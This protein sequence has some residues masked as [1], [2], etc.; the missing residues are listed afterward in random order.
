MKRRHWTTPEKE[1]HRMFGKNQSTK[2]REICK[3]VYV[4]ILAVREATTAQI[5]Q[6]LKKRNFLKGRLKGVLT[7][8]IG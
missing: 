6:I 4:V 1:K 2:R 5:H 8:M 7:K 3:K